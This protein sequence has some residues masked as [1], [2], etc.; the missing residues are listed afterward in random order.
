MGMT[1]YPGLREELRRRGKT[2]S[3][4]ARALGISRRALWRKQR[5]GS[6]DDFSGKEICLAC[7]YLD[8]PAQ[9]LFSE[10]KP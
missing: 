9:K 7:Q 10:V 8:A 2:P 4:L 6:S 3:E 5:T 1:K